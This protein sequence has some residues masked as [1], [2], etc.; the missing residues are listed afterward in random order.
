MPAPVQAPQGYGQKSGRPV[1]AMVSG[2]GDVTHRLVERHAPWDEFLPG[3]VPLPVI[4]LSSRLILLTRTAA[5]RILALA[6]ALPLLAL[7]VSPV[8]AFVIHRFGTD[9]DSCAG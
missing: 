2:F 9:T 8:V 4:L 7:I 1:T 5:L 3:L 6:V